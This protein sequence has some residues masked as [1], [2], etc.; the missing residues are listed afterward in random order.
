ME[1]FRRMW[2]SVCG[3]FALLFSF[4]SKPKVSDRRSP[5]T[6]RHSSCSEMPESLSQK[7]Q[8]QKKPKKS[9]ENEK[10]EFLI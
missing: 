6:S 5:P 2:S 3:F 4:F 10:G 1:R 8:K 7:K 9:W